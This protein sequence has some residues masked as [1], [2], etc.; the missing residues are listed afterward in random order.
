MMGIVKEAGEVYLGNGQSFPT[1]RLYL[2][3][4]EVSFQNMEGKEVGA[5]KHND[6]DLPEGHKSHLAN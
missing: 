1:M 5:T 6:N 4:P 2:I 3:L